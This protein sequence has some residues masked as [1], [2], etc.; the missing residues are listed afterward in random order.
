MPMEI[1]PNDEN[2]STEIICIIDKSGS[3]NSIK[4]DAIGGF[5]SFLNEQKELEDDTKI[6][7][8]L[9]DSNYKPLYNS[10]PLTEAEELNEQNYVPSSMTAL[11]DA[12][13]L[14]IDEAKERYSN[15]P[16]SKPD[17]VLVVIL[18]DGEE[19]RS[20]EYDQKRVFEMIEEQ[21]ND[22]WEFIFLAANQDAMK[23]A[24][25]M[26]ISAGNSM[27]FAPTGQGTEA[28]YTAM[29]ASV[30]SYRSSKLKKASKLMRDID[31]NTEEKS[32]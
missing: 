5:N 21:K 18:T 28:V 6:T 26:N 20:R 31:D 19:N 8:S 27:D 25:A 1:V 24:R 32:N 22:D 29:S 2:L 30:K 17:R 3:M 10:L 12:V 14:S 13:G 15:D 7:V 4:S 11:Y 16:S 9:F 23:A